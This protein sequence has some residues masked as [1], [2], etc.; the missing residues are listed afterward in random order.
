MKNDL[1]VFE[2]EQFGNVRV[3]NQ[4]DEV[5]FV[6]K[7]LADC[8]E[9]ADV[10]SSTRDFDL[11][12]KGTH[13]VQTLGGEQKVVILSEAGM[14]RLILKSRKTEAK[15]FKRWITHEVL[16]SIR[17]HGAYLTPDK[18]EEV[19]LNPDTIIELA[20]QLKVEIEKRREAE[21][22]IEE[23][24]PLV[25]FAETCLKSNDNILIRELSKIAKE[26]GINIGQNRLYEKLREWK[27]IMKGSTEPYQYSMERKWFVVE[28]KSINTPYG[29]KLTKTTKVTPKGQ[30][31][32]IEKL[33][34][35]L[36]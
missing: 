13:T 2:N 28:E 30:V 32:I 31:Y 34:S 23:Q 9:I 33:K 5:W 36:K 20:T 17:K 35:E 7:D 4:N 12:E 29:V 10:S 8:L 15:Q 18:I 11:D 19:L 16:P 26:E 1:M 14:Y 22:Q 3:I 6:A 25:T 21:K 27:L 24:K